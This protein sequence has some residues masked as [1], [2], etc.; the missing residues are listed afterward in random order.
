[1][2]AS[3]K[4]K[5]GKKKPPYKAQASPKGTKSVDK[6]ASQLMAKMVAGEG[7]PKGKITGS[8]TNY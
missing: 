7:K 8:S 3:K 4:P 2:H 1:M 6:A 5:G